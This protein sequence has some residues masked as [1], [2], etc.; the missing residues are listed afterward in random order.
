ML[1][2]IRV[3][4]K[5]RLNFLQKIIKLITKPRLEIRVGMKMRLKT[6]FLERYYFHRSLR[7]K[8]TLIFFFFFLSFLYVHDM[9]EFHSAFVVYGEY[10]HMQA[11]N[12]EFED[13][14][15]EY[16]KQFEGFY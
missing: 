11:I 3:N 9:G 4:K 13:Y 7:R 5:S 12:K 10:K 8:I 2:K 16:M 14:M 6:S 15:K 1:K